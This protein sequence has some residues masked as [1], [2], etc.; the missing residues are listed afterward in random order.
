MQIP[1]NLVALG[2]NENTRP[3]PPAFWHLSNTKVQNRIKFQLFCSVQLHRPLKQN[4]DFY[5]PWVPSLWRFGPARSQCSATAWSQ[6]AAVNSFLFVHQINFQL[7]DPG[8][9]WQ[10]WPVPMGTPT[11]SWIGNPECHNDVTFVSFLS[12]GLTVQD[13]ANRSCISD[14][15]DVFA[16]IS[17][18]NV[19]IWPWL[20]LHLHKLPRPQRVNLATEEVTPSKPSQFYCAALQKRLRQ[21]RLANEKQGSASSFAWLWPCHQKRCAPLLLDSLRRFDPAMRVTPRAM[22]YQHCFECNAWNV[23]RTLHNDLAEIA[24]SALG[25]L[26][27]FV[28]Q[29]AFWFFSSLQLLAKKCSDTRRVISE[30]LNWRYSPI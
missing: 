1:A 5:K 9:M 8:Y 10:V 27:V 30:D 16:S 28:L 2:W 7:P 19:E 21:L 23:K 17:V 6:E 3:R 25:A 18:A 29:G 20:K 4:L 24:E 14:F 11:T 15:L 26:F 13:Q 22:Q 12:F